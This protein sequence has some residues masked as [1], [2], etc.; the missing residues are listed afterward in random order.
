MNEAETKENITST[1][2]VI[3]FPHQLQLHDWDC[4]VA[5]VHSILSY[6][7]HNFPYSSLLAQ[8][9][10]QSV[11]TIDLL[12]LLRRLEIP[13][14][15]YTK[16]L[17]IDHGFS[18]YKKFYADLS[19]DERRVQKLFD[20]AEENKISITNVSLS[21]EEIL[22]FLHNSAIL[23]LLVDDR[24][25]CCPRC[26]SPLEFDKKSM[27]LEFAGH[28]IVLIGANSQQHTV[29]YYDPSNEKGETCEISVKQL[30]MARK[31]HGTDEDCIIIPN[32]GPK[33]APTRGIRARTS[34]QQPSKAKNSAVSS[35]DLLSEIDMSY[36]LFGR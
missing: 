11:W 12:Y 17:G 31:S 8:F 32:H 2:N 28:F 26:V 14:Q 16:T 24:Y 3:H 30:E 4:G 7:G 6:F 9:P 13:C 23:L 5:A 15:F 19:V 20:S 22:Q 21:T 29:I 25:L 35:K 18:I 10:D 36:G 33:L 27:K 1:T 34:E